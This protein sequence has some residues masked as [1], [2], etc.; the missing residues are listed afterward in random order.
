MLADAEEQLAE[1]AV[2]E[3]A[4][5]RQASLTVIR[6][7]AETDDLYEFTPP[8]IVGR[9]D[10]TVGP[11]DVDLGNTPEGQYV[12][13]KH[14]EIRF[15]DG[16][17]RVRD[18]GSSNGTFLLKEDFEKVE[19]AEIVDGDKIAFGNARFIF[20]VLSGAEPETSA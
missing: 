9:F 5:I 12:S 16:A 11:I 14:A 20:R 7:G 6:G 17:W 2:I 18:L 13:R 8:A 10:P 3:P 4:G 1:Q 19:D 15:E